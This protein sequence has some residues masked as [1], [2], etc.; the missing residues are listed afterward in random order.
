MTNFARDLGKA[1]EASRPITDEEIEAGA[2]A[3]HED[4]GFMPGR[5]ED[6]KNSAWAE[7]LRR[8]VRVT[9]TIL[10]GAK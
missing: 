8:N 3:L 10:R 1:D 4:F 7:S 9:L 6:V 5:W 2:R